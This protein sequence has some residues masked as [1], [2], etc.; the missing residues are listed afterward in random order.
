LA[1]RVK[2]IKSIEGRVVA[3]CLSTWFF[4]YVLTE[5]S[6]IPTAVWYNAYGINMTKELF[7]GPC[8]GIVPLGAAVGVLL[9]HFTMNKFDRR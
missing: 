5:I 7:V 8:F 4:G 2:S 1:N 3:L 9:A 6:L